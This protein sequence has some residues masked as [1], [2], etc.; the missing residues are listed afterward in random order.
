MM[1]PSVLIKLVLLDLGKENPPKI[2]MRPSTEP[3]LTTLFPTFLLSSTGL[4]GQLQ[5]YYSA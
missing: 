2:P 3:Y 5:V 1:L 4:N